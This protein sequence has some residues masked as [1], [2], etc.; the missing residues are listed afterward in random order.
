MIFLRD[1]KVPVTLFENASTRGG[2]LDANEAQ[3]FLAG[4]EL[5]LRKNRPDVV[6][7]YGGDAVSLLVQRLAKQLDVPVLFG[8]HNF[9]YRD[10]EA[11]RTVDYVVVPSEFARRYYWDTL[12]LGCLKLPCIIDWRRVEAPKREPRYVT[13]VNPVPWKGVRV[14]A[15]IAEVLAR[16]RPDIP[17]LVVEGASKAGVPAGLGID[18]GGIP[19]LRVMRN[20]PDPR[21]FYAATKIVL[22]PSL[23]NESF[24]LVA[25]EAMINGIPVLA[26]TRGALPETV[27][28]GGF[29]FDI[30]AQY[31]PESPAIP[32]TEEVEPWVSTIIRLWDDPVAYRQASESA[33]Q[34]AQ[35]WRPERLATIYREFF[36]N[37]FPQPSPPLVPIEMVAG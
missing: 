18:L 29:L 4:C 3:A 22:M 11:F 37:L 33:S 35:R 24:G 17:L 23:W 28:D 14:F 15:R 31:T 27:G 21:D 25:A 9:A 13:L 2:W 16:R 8:L 20:T 6:W 36:S 26:S 10:P 5:F 7:T 30:P 1:G 32:S 12:G 19:G 34:W